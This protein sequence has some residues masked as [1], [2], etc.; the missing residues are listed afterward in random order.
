MSYLLSGGTN[1]GLNNRHPSENWRSFSTDECLVI[2]R[3]SNL[4]KTLDSSLAGPS[5]V[6][7]RLAGMT[8]KGVFKLSP[9]VGPAG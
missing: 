6:E 8:S 9:S 3:L 4:S 2:Q 7:E 1:D 5:A